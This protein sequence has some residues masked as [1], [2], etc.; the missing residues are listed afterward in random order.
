MDSPLWSAPRYPE[1]GMDNTDPFVACLN[2]TMQKYR[3]TGDPVTLRWIFQQ[4]H[5]NRVYPPPEVMDWLANGVLQDDPNE[6]TAQLGLKAERGKEN[7]IKKAER[8]GRDNELAIW[9]YYLCRH[10]GIAVAA[11]ADGVY[12][13]ELKAGRDAS[14]ATW[15]EAQYRRH[16]KKH[17]ATDPPYDLFGYRPDLLPEFLDSFPM[18]WLQR[19]GLKC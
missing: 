14:S 10:T 5:N 12:L 17:F 19:H 4:C 2:S 16:W 11:A 1:G 6:I 3:E 9:I 15:I 7:P 8:T 13:R 18:E